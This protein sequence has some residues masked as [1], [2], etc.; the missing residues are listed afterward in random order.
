MNE[1]QRLREGTPSR[2]ESE[3]LTAGVDYRSS[4][5]ARRKTLTALG[6]AGTAMVSA[7]VAGSSSAALA[8]TPPV[9]NAASLGSTS[10][11]AK[12]GWVK[13][14]TA[15]VGAVAVVPVAYSVLH[16]DRAAESA[17]VAPSPKAPAPRVLEAP[18]RHPAPVERTEPAPSPELDTEAPVQTRA[19]VPR[20][21]K[22][23]SSPREKAT[24]SA[25]LSGELMALD[26]ARAKLVQGDAT[27]ALTALDTFERAHPD[28]R[29]KL[30][31]EVLRIDA[32]AQSGRGA[33][34]RKRAEAFLSRHPNSVLA[35]RVR[36]H[37][38]D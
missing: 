20:A 14:I 7:T 6:L 28:A 15:A 12:L 38:D 21:P 13:I 16:E 9:A 33:A 23:A 30:E 26:A 31:A 10:L 29:M 34:A 1:P 11:L 8:S 27:E 5:E 17:V 37:L 32:L 36:A 2:F 35:A 4:R 18:D 3:L 24:P 25:V 19:P 22:A